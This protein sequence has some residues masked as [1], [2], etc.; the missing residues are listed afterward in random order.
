MNGYPFY[1]E[2]K[3]EKKYDFSRHTGFEETPLTTQFF[4]QDNIYRLHEL[5]ILGV[6]NYS[7]KKFIISKQDD[8]ALRIIMR[9]I[10]LQFSINQS[11]N[12]DKQ[13]ITLNS[14]V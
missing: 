12:I 4:S 8:L 9:S 10:Y 5:L 3:K 6:Y 13:V 2:E 14:K 7:D 11:T 1:E